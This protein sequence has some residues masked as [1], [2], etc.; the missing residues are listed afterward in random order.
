[1][2]A[3]AATAAVS[4]PVEREFDKASTLESGP[5]RL[6]ERSFAMTLPNF[7]VIGAHRSGT[8]SLYSYFRQH[9]QSYM[10]AWIKEARFFCYDPDDPVHR[11]KSRAIFPV[12]TLEEY[13]ALFDEVR[14]QVAIG[15][16]SPEY[17]RNS[18]AGAR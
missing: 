7:L 9:P 5:E 12:R 3:R 2:I 16:A 17:L 15:E 11:A 14:G 1:M 8:T 13:T 4:A 18:K 10:P 6:Q